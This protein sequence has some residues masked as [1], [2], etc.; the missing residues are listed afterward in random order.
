MTLIYVGQKKRLGCF[1]KES[2]HK[3]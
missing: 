1:L 3:I 2:N